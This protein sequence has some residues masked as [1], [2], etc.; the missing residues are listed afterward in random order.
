MKRLFFLLLITAFTH[1]IHAQGIKW[2]PRIGVSTTQVSPGQLVVTNQAGLDSLTL[3]LQDAKYGF[4]AGLFLRIQTA[5]KLFFQ[6]ELHFSTTTVEYRI[7]ELNSAS[8]FQEIA[9]ETYY[10]LNLPIHAGLKF[11]PKIVSFRVQGGVIISKTLGGST[12]VGTIIQDYNQAF[13]DL[14]VGWQAGVGLDVWKITLDV[15]YEGDFGN[16]ASHMQFFGND[17]EFDDRERQIKFSLGWK[18]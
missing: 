1:S 16:Y 15:R 10:D 12:T 11:G 3:N 17:V 5:K 18:F 9:S 2:G 4:N 6:T 14:N 8:P 7:D 13:E